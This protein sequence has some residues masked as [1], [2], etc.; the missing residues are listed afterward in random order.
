MNLMS[1]SAKVD[2]R[3]KMGAFPCHSAGHDV[4]QCVLRTQLPEL[5]DVC[6]TSEGRLVCHA[7]LADEGKQPGM[8]ARM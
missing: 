3:K 2:V 7:K 8:M 6:N 5:C 1:Y 4:K